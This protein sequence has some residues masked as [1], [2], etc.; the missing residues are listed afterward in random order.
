MAQAIAINQS[1]ALGRGGKSERL[2]GMITTKK[3]F[4]VVFSS[5]RCFTK[6]L[7]SKSR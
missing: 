4:K 1:K 6:D 7:K 2:Y 3:K 5:L